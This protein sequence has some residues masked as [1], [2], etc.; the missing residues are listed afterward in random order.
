MT[1]GSYGG[2]MTLVA[3]THYNDR[4]RA[5]IDIVGM[6]NLVTFLE[7]TESYRR[8][9]RRREY[10]DERDPKM[11]EY[12]ESVAPM[13]RVKS[14]TKPMFIVAGRNDPRVPVSESDQ[15]AAALK[16]NGTP[17]WYLIGND[18]GHGFAKRKNQDV[19]FYA[20]VHF[21]QTYL[22]N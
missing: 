18:E 22:L 5:S 17:R 14:V 4:I 9:L 7:R 2:H 8:D 3:A 21:I 16:A 20:T 10:G 19:Q 6:S 12:Q 15:I 11:R 1:G 13:N